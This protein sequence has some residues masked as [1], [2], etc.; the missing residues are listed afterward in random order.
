MD[1]VAPAVVSA[2]SAIPSAIAAT[3]GAAVGLAAAAYALAT[4]VLAYTLAVA[5][6]A[7]ALAV[8]PVSLAWRVLFLVLSPVIY[9]VGYVLAPLWF[10]VGLAPKLQPLYIYVC[11]YHFFFSSYMPC[12]FGT[13]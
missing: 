12:V 8:Y 11:S 9:T 3:A 2:L 4:T 10:L 5:G 13:S 6:A 1:K 7:F